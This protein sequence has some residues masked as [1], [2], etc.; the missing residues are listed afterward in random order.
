MLN[1]FRKNRK[2]VLGES[3]KKKPSSPIG[4]YLLY[5]IGEIF[6]VMIGIL[7][8]L[9]VNSWNQKRLDSIKEK[10]LLSTVYEQM[11][12]LDFFQEGGY[13]QYSDV[14][15]S[16]KDIL[17]AIND[18]SLP[19]NKEQLDEDL[20]MISNIRWL[21][22]A[23]NVTNIYDLLIG[24]GQWELL[25]SKELRTTLK[26]LNSHLEFLLTFEELQ[27]N[28]VDNHLSPF[29][30][31]HIDRI[32]ISPERFELDP[33]LKNNRFETS[34]EELLESQKFSNLLV[35]LI[36]HTIVLVKT[37][38]RMGKQIS[39]IDSCAIAGNPSIKTSL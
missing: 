35:E 21:T 28:F 5:A 18:P 7:L 17:A 31:D 16:A 6:L 12:Q 30:N 33:S 19:L 39:V 24:S 29:L 13:A 10:K 25:S 38:E 1:F 22:G 32:S 11:R 26:T 37:L 27:S 36:R 2:N 8:A 23:S 3:S 14:M 4:R 20:N 34:Y 9:Q 15:L